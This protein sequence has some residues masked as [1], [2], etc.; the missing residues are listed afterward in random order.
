MGV[1]VNANFFFAHSV[2]YVSLMVLDGHRRLV[3]LVRL[4]DDE[5][6]HALRYGICTSLSGTRGNVVLQGLGAP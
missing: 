2:I 3:P 5:G 4:F 1:F 6:Q